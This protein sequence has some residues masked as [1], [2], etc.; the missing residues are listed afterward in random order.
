MKGN[1][2]KRHSN[3]ITKLFSLSKDLLRRS[4]VKSALLIVLSLVLPITACKNVN[5][6]EANSALESSQ[7][8]GKLTP[9]SVINLVGQQDALF[10]N[11]AQ[12]KEFNSI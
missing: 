9:Q 4:T 1:P 6:E 11:G 5:H 3:V 2:M 12:R 10:K 8:G 7:K